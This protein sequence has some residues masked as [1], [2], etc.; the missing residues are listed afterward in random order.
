MLTNEEIKL[1]D[2]L[3]LFK[4]KCFNKFEFI[5]DNDPIH[6]TVRV[7]YEKYLEDYY[8]KQNISYKQ[9]RVSELIGL[10]EKIIAGKRKS[11]LEKIKASETRNDNDALNELKCD[12]ERLNSDDSSCFTQVND[13]SRNDVNTEIFLQMP[14]FLK[15]Q[16]KTSSIDFSQYLTITSD[17]DY[18]FVIYRYIWSLGYYLTSNACKFGGDYLVYSGDPCQYHSKFILLCL[19]E[20]KFKEIKLKQL[21]HYGRIATNVKKLY[22]IACVLQ[23]NSDFSF[24]NSIKFENENILF[25]CIK[26][27]HM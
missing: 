22:L 18:K 3:R 27:S 23:N 14:A 1:L 8:D 9:K 26:W 13:L 17:L 6:E 16:Y 11:L 19:N 5:D 12:L 2:Y 15:K 25:T 10:K 7:E 4:I 20:E 21:I 24:K